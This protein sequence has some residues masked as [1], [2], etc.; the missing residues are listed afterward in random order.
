M[1]VVDATGLKTSMP[2]G[3]DWTSS[4]TACWSLNVIGYVTQL[5]DARLQVRC[6]F[7]VSIANGSLLV[8]S[9]GTPRCSGSGTTWRAFI[10]ASR[11]KMDTEEEPPGCSPVAA[12]ILK[13][14]TL[15]KF[16][17]NQEG[18]CKQAELEK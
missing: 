4:D 10:K 15:P 5:F 9:L 8:A 13:A 12:I 2:V 3:V 16:S 1:Y 14:P 6:L 18:Q 7:V 17:D 11:I